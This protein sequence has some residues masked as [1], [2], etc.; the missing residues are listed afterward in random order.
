MAKLT[1][2]RDEG[3]DRHFLDG[4]PV[5]AG[6]LL[7]L[8]MP[9]GKWLAVRYESSWVGG[10]HP[11]FILA[12]GPAKF[13]SE[14]DVSTGTAEIILRT[15]TWD[16]PSTFDPRAL[17]RAEFRW[18]QRDATGRAEKRDDTLDTTPRRSV[19]A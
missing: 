13:D 11:R 5:H 2:G 14:G 12:V 18:P 9:S 16:D 10:F 3:G 4:R 8:L 7:E 19:N 6:A 1:A 15:N 17:A